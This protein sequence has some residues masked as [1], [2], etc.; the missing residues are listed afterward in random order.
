MF[1]LFFR[2]MNTSIE[3]SKWPDDWYIS[4]IE[5]AKRMSVSTRTIEVWMGQNRIPFEKIGRTV[6][7]HWGDVRAFISRRNRPAAQTGN[8]SLPVEGARARLKELAVSIRKQHRSHAS[9]S[10]S[11]VFHPCS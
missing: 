5:M 1:F 11:T 2:L 4:K 7:F 6:R 8:R 10:T 3:N 9:E